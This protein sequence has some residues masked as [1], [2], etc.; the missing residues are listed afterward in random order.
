LFNL[1]HNTQG[2]TGDRLYKDLVILFEN[3]TFFETANSSFAAFI[4]SNLS[5]YDANNIPSFF[6]FNVLETYNSE[7]PEN[8]FL[9]NNV[10]NFQ[11]IGITSGL[12]QASDLFD[13]FIV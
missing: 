6:F 10:Q 2:N 7:V 5:F 3:Q 1:N 8:N 12:F 4:V 11:D 13:L 9:I